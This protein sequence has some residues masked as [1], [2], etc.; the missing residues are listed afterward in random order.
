VTQFPEWFKKRP[1]GTIQYAENPPKKYQDIYPLHFESPDRLALWSELNRVLE[2]WIKLGVKIFRVDNPHTKPF[3]FWEYL[4][5]D[6]RERHADVVF[7]SEAFT[8]P[9]LMYR[10]AKLGFTQSYTYFTW[11]NT[12]DEL[13]QYIDEISKPPVSDFFRGNLWP[14]TPDILHEYLQKG[15]LAAFAVRYVLAATLSSNVGIYG[16]VYEWG[17]NTPLSPGSEEYLDSEKYEIKH[18]DWNRTAPLTQLITRVNAIR[19]QQ[20]ALQRATGVS[21]LP[22]TSEHIIAYSRYYPGAAPIVVAVNLDPHQ[23]RAAL[24]TMDVREFG[25]DPQRPF[26]VRDLLDN[27][28]Y[29]WQGISHYVELNPAQRTS[30]IFLVEQTW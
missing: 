28:E 6:I 24:I 2:Y 13:T 18:W 23:T 9:K 8:R 21:F 30:H 17:I 15:G 22:T 26:R 7:L 14:N 5:H 19:R 25:L 1:D 27:S 29:Y 12:K 11:R 3:A 16:P 20:M 4:I 10:L